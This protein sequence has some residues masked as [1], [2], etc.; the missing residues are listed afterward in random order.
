MMKLM[1]NLS[2]A[3]ALGGAMGGSALIAAN[4]GLEILG[5]VMF[6][7]SSVA[8]IYLLTNTENAPRALIYQNIFFVCV[9][10]FGLWRHGLN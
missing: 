8:S 3:V 5:Y 2:S 1:R 4:V 6:L 7:A 9:N 10:V